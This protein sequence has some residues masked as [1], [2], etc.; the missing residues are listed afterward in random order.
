[1]LNIF[2]G[3]DSRQPIAYTVLQHSLVTRASKP[4]MV[5]PLLLKQLPIQRRGLT[6]FTFSRYLVPYLCD[7][8]GWALFLDADFLC[9][10]DV[11]ELLALADPHCAV[12]VV[13]H[14]MAFEWPSLML[15][16]CEACRTLTPDYIETAQPNQLQW[17]KVGSLPAEWNFLVGYDQISQPF[18]INKP[19]KMVHYTQGIPAFLEMK[20]TDF[21]D[22]WHA[23]LGQCLETTSWWELM[24][25]SV[26]AKPVIE[27]LQTKVNAQR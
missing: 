20:G 15:F 16:N 8:Q 17:G 1:M 2:V 27:R 25:N 22:D 13:Q 9:L 24:G 19:V 5:S 6:D 12:Q 3:V 23:E 26:H 21:Y 4:V 14:A 7:Y 18:N 10:A 11:Y